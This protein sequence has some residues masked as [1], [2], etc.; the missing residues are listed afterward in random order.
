MTAFPKIGALKN[1]QETPE[2]ALAGEAAVLDLSGALYLP[3]RDTLLVA[4][5]HFEKGS[6]FARRGMFLPPYD[7]RET[8]ACLHEVIARLDPVCVVALGRISGPRF[9]QARTLSCVTRV[10]WRPGRPPLRTLSPTG[11]S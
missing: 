5:L 1:K 2:V 4:D 7:T 6:S 9:Q 3:D 10:P 11:R 8:L